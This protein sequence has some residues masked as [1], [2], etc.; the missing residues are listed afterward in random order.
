MVPIVYRIPPVRIRKAV[1]KSIAVRSGFHATTITQPSTR[2]KARFMRSSRCGHLSFKR[3]PTNANA[4]IELVIQKL[5]FSGSIRAVNGVYVPAIRRK[6][7]A[8]ST[9]RRIS[10]RDP[11]RERLYTAEQQSMAIRQAE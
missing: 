10:R 2:Y 5:H 11:L 9:R 7:A 6:I 1:S 4:Q 3:A 8:W